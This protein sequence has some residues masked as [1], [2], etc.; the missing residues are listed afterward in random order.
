MLLQHAWL[1]ELLKPAPIMEEDEDA[2]PPETQ[3]EAEITPED[4]TPGGIVDK[5]VA[6]WVR[7]ALERRRLGKM[8]KGE[9]PALHAAPL[10]VVVSPEAEVVPSVAEEPKVEEPKPAEPATTETAPELVP[11]EAKPEEPATE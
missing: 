1:A 2:T 6:E 11:E 9:K 7:N 4:E 3:P 5:E 10:D 8:K